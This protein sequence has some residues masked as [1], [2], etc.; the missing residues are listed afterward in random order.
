MIQEHDAVAVF[1]D[2]AEVMAHKEDRLALFFELL[3][4]MIAFCLEKDVSHG[5]CLIYNQDLRVDIDRHS[6][7]QADKHTAGVGFHGLVD[8]IADICESQNFRKTLV[9]FL[10]RE[11]QHRTVEVNVFHASILHV[12]TGSQLQKS[13]DSAVHRHISHR[14]LQHA[15]DDLQHRRFSGTVGS[16]DAHGLSSVYIKAHLI[17]GFVFPVFLFLCKPKGLF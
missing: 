11:A 1:A 13:G 5:K 2:A 9:N 10:L 6:E 7:G 16:D 12:E 8:E 3:E 14:R 17:Q 15:G 4:L